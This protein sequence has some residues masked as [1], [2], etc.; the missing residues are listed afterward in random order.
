M[1]IVMVL[2]RIGQLP[3]QFSSLFGEVVVLIVGAAHMRRTTN[4]RTSANETSRGVMCGGVDTI[5]EKHAC[6]K[7]RVLVCSHLEENKV[8]MKDETEV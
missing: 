1:W 8:T 2:K 6:A 5:E 7:K 4:G 3:A